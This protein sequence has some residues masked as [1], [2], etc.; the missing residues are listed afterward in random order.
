[1]TN[2]HIKKNPILLVIREMQIIP[3][4]N[5]NLLPT[6]FKKIVSTKL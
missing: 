2:T 4:A 5:N 6:G 1:M 3:K